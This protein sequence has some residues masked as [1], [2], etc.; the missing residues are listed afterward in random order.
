MGHATLLQPAASRAR[1]SPVGHLFLHA[2]RAHFSAERLCHL[3][4]DHRHLV[5]HCQCCFALSLSAIHAHS[6]GDALR[7]PLQLFASA[8]HFYNG[9]CVCRG[10]RKKI[11]VVDSLG[12]DSDVFDHGCTFRVVS[13]LFLQPHGRCVCIG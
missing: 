6:R 7:F 11:R 12:N 10:G 2:S 3:T 5:T 13:R 4:L 8:L 9:E 1:S